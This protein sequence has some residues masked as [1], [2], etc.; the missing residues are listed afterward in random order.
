LSFRTLSEVEWGR[1]LL[2]AVATHSAIHQQ[3]VIST[4]AARALCEQRSGEIRFSTST[5]SQ[6]RLI[7]GIFVTHLHR[8]KTRCHEQYD[9]TNAYH[10]DMHGNQP[11]FN[12][13]NHLRL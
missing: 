2:L 10:P 8:D 7:V 4:E 11:F 3:T 13:Q 9:E 1:N 5:R 6:P 12:L